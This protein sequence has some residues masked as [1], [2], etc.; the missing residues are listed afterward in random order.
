MFFYTKVPDGF[1][2]VGVGVRARPRR[3]Q[4]TE[5]VRYKSNIEVDT[6]N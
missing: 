5:A 3:P 2:P 4:E 1:M 6:L